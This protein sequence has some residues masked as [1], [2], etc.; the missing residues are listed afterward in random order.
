MKIL[1]EKYPMG[2][3]KGQK[4]PGRYIDG[5]LYENLQTMARKIVDD[6]TFMGICFSSTLEVGTGK[7]VFMT[8]IGEVWTHLVNKEHGLNLEFTERNL[9][10]NAKDLI[11]RAMELPKYSLILLDEWEDASYW[12][13]LGQALRKFLRKCRQLNL[14]IICIIPNWFQLPLGFAVSRS[15]FAI[16]VKFESGFKR[17]FFDFYGFEAKRNLYVK[18][19]KFY[20]YHVQKPTFYGRFTDG[21]GLPEKEYRAAKL[22]DLQESE[23]LEKK[24]MNETEYRIKLYRG[25]R[26]R[27]PKISVRDWATYFGVSKNTISAWN[28]D[29]KERNSGTGSVQNPLYTTYN[30][31]PIIKEDIVVYK[32]AEDED[33]VYKK[34]EEPTD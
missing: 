5:I 24:P 8:Q 32:S 12:S 19:K 27:K 30:K 29:K 2:S 1:E 33:V 14:C 21:Y 18:G 15:A 31:E 23:E 25:M 7:S 34:M 26:D 20:N 17:G 28:S 4:S 9:V 11:S 3:F 13:A 16:D 22:K 6:M 10:F